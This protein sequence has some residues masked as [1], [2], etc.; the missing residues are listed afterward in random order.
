VVLRDQFFNVCEHQHAPAR[1]P[2]QFGNNK[3]FARAGG[4][5]NHR[6]FIVVA[7]VG[8]GSV[9]RFALIRA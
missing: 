2:C 1:H 3:A 4:Q 5:D 8:E 7:K 9:Y 6:R